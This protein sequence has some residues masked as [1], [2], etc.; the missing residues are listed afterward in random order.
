MLNINGKMIM[1]KR[2]LPHLENLD[3]SSGDIEASM[4]LSVDGLVIAA[5]L[6]IC[7]NSDNIGAICA[8]AFSMGHRASKEC[9]CGVLEQVII[10]CRKNQIVISYLSAEIILAVI[11]KPYADFEQL[12]SNLKQ[13]IEKI[14]TVI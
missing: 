7:I 10:K 6:P 14:T 4:L 8:S 3:N 13:S 1:Y 9:A 2:I 12:F 5:T 11:I